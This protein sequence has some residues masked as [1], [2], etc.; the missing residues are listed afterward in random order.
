MGRGHLQQWRQRVYHPI[1]GLNL[2][3]SRESYRRAVIIDNDP[4]T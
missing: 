4:D 1:I 3:D 2:N